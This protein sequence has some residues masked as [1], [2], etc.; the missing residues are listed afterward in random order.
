M[1]YARGYKLNIEMMEINIKHDKLEPFQKQDKKALE[2]LIT[3]RANDPD[4]F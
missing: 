4:V 2:R 3:L 1:I